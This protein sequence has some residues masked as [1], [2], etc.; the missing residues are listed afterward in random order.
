[1]PGEFPVVVA[2]IEAGVLIPMSQSLFAH[3]RPGG[4]LTL[5][6]IL[7]PQADDVTRAYESQGGTLEAKYE[8]G[9][10][11]ALVLRR[12]APAG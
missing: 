9:E 4:F 12:P 5:S 1:V 8:R 6:G 7:L 10:W 11:V 2:N 3:V